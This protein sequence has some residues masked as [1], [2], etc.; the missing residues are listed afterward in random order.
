MGRSSSQPS[1]G[2]LFG[3]GFPP[4]YLWRF[5]EFCAPLIPEKRNFPILGNQPALPVSEIPDKDFNFISFIREIGFYPNSINQQK[6]E[7][8]VSEMLP[9]KKSN[10]DTLPNEAF[11]VI[12]NAVIDKGISFR[13]LGVK[14]TNRQ[15]VSMKNAKI[16]AE[17]TD[18]ILLKSLVQKDSP[19]WDKIESI[20]YIQEEEVYDLT[21]PEYHN[22]IANGIIVH[23]S[24]YA[25]CGIIVNVTPF[26]PE[27]EGYITIE[28]SNTTPLPAKIYANEGI[29]Q[30]LFFEGDAQCEVTY[31][32]RK[33]K[34]QN[35][36]GITLPRILRK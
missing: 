1:Q 30:V 8:I 15:S 4:I 5:W 3:K 18:D 14:P 25:R 16:V 12:K 33:G 9:K 27:F 6:L 24:T 26:E 29:A 20:E 32:S 23:N 10:F 31:K 13:S 36:T 34:Y 35:Q 17:A 19:I 2:V 28:I 7:K 21:I 22:F 11:A